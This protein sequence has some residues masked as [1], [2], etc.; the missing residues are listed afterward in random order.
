M[1]PH[2]VPSEQKHFAFQN[3]P[4]DENGVFHLWCRHAEGNLQFRL[5]GGS[6]TPEEAAQ[7]REDVLGKGYVLL[8][9]AEANT[10]NVATRYPDNPNG[11]DAGIAGLINSNGRIMGNMAHPEV[12]C[13]SS[14]HPNYFK[15]VDKIRRENVRIEDL[16]KRMEVPVG[17][18]I[19]KNI[20]NY[21]R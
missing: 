5:N 7:T 11:S 17:K 10:G 4:A 18:V 20:V 1:V 8:K 3:I 15:M 2:I 14:T 19:F 9:Y 16:E 12:H 13:I 21:V 6:I